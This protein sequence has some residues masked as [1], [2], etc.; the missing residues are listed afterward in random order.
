MKRK[1]LKKHIRDINDNQIQPIIGQDAFLRMNMQNY[2]RSEFKTEANRLRPVNVD[3]MDFV[4]VYNMSNAWDYVLKNIKKTIDLYEI[5]N[6]NS[7]IAQNNDQ[8]IVGG[9]YRYSFAVALGQMAPNPDKI[10]NLLDDAVYKMNSGK[11]FILTKAFNIHYDIIT[12]QPFMDFNKRTARIIMNWFL[13]KNNYTP[14]LFNQKTDHTEYTE[15]IKAR[16]NGDNKTYTSYMCEKMLKTQHAILN[17]LR[18]KS[19]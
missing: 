15:K 16:M 11:D 13:L 19:R 18:A 3:R 6:V 8:N 10:Y 17:M 12:I 5:R 4:N 14:I 2:I 9:A 1:D 7:I